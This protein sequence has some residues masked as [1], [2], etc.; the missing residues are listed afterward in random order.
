M[1][2]RGMREIWERGGE[3]KEGG[4]GG[5]GKGRGRNASYGRAETAIRATSTQTLI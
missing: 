2:V 4:R 3:K 5:G 1:S